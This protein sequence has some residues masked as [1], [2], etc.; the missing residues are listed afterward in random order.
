MVE[1]ICIVV[2][3]ICIVVENICIVVENIFIVVENICTER[4]MYIYGK[5]EKIKIDLIVDI[6]KSLR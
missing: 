3:N 1:N 4:K 6:K 5:T 2:E